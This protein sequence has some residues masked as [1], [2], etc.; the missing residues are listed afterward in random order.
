MPLS[1]TLVDALTA[2]TPDVLWRLRGDLVEAGVAADAP[3]W[4]VLD[5]FHAYL[6]RLEV[7][8]TSRSFSNLASMLDISA[9]SGVLLEN[10]GEPAAAATV[11]R[12]LL[13]SGVSEGLMALATRQHVKAWDGELAGVHRE[14]AWELW[15]ELGQWSARQSPELTPAQRRAMLDGLLEPVVTGSLT[16]AA[17]AFLLGRVYQAVLLGTLAEAVAEAAKSTE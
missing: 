5:A 14:A 6:H 13:A 7:G 12:R 11:A 16:G 1:T 15:R 4:G 9:I 2:V 10:L 8:T 17:P 3:V